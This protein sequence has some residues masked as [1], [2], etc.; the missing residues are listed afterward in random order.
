MDQVEEDLKRIKITGWRAKVEDRQEWNRIV[1]QTKTL[2]GLQSQ[3]KKKKKEKEKEEEECV[4]VALGIQHAMRMRH[5]LICGL[6]GST[7]FNIN[8]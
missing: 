3:Q 5:I 2:P 8:S 7:F 6:L 4:F 1:E